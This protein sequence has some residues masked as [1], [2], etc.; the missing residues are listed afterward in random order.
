MTTKKRQTKAERVGNRMI[1]AAYEFLYSDYR[2]EE[3]GRFIQEAN[4]IMKGRE[5]LTG[6]K[7]RRRLP[8]A[9]E[10]C[11]DEPKL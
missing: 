1:S 11:P 2:S 9:G 10:A 8:S 5:S 7:G 4:R 3:W 6:R